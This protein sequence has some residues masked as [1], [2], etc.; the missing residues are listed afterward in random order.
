LYDGEEETR[1]I[2]HGI[3]VKPGVTR[4]EGWDIAWEGIL[5]GTEN[6]TKGIFNDWRVEDNHIGLDF[7]AA[8]VQVGDIFKLTNVGQAKDEAIDG[9]NPC[10]SGAGQDESEHIKTEFSV[11]AVELNAIELAPVDG[12]DLAAC[13]NEGFS[14]HLRAKQAWTV[15]GSKS[16][17]MP[18]IDMIPYQD[19]PPETPAYDNGLIALTIYEPGIDPDTGEPYKIRRDTAW[20]FNTD[21][22]FVN[23]RFSP[24]VQ[25]GVAGEMAP[26]DLDMDKENRVDDRVFIIFEGSNAMMEFFPENLESTTYNLYQ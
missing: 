4:S 9:D 10:R 8:G 25:A 11:T 17:T 15:W 20:N 1:N 22:G 2:Y 5:R 18:R 3:S 24:V 13:W 19:T 14:Y 23:V 12:I 6:S 7:I 26:V 16:G 21:D